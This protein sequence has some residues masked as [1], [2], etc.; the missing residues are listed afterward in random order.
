MHMMGK[1]IKQDIKTVLD[2][3]W[4]DEERHYLESGRSKKHIF[5]T[6]KRL[7]KRVKS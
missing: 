4:R 7:A 5:H 1:Q 6:L 2:Y 3:L